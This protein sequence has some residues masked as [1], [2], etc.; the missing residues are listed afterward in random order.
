MFKYLKI[1][2]I[3]MILYILAVPLFVL[4]D[5]TIL[6][7]DTSG[8]M[9]IH[10][11]WEAQTA[12]LKTLGEIKGSVLIIG[13]D[14]NDYEI[15]RGDIS[16]ANRQAV[17]NSVR[18]RLNALIPKGPYTH[19]E[20]ALDCG[21]IF[22]MS[23]SGNGLRKLILFT[24]G[25]NRPVQDVDK[26]HRPIDLTQVAQTIIPKDFGFSVY[27]IGLT[28]DL[29]KFF[30]AKSDSTGFISDNQYPHIKG[31]PVNDYKPASVNQAFSRAVSDTLSPKQLV[32]K[33]HTMLVS[34]VGWLKNHWLLIGLIIIGIILIIT[35]ITTL[36][37]KKE[38]T[39]ITP[40]T[41]LKTKQPGDIFINDLQLLI[42][43]PG[44]PEVHYPLTEGTVYTLGIDVPIPSIDQGI[45]VIKMTSGLVTIEPLTTELIR[46][47]QEING[48]SPLSMGD[49][50]QYQDISFTLTNFLDEEMV[51][52]ISAADASENQQN[53]QALSNEDYNLL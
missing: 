47:E 45:A 22:L 53:N 23:T 30:Q 34:F 33:R 4:A 49:I 24:D 40:V 44:L 37:V 20:E 12:I 16:E 28:A 10:G 32:A 9:K 6:A 41:E 19:I 26:Y 43:C 51:S 5:V 8:S 38:S 13:F 50:I 31:I 2:V 36:K 42:Q 18:D 35:A 7:L 29:E 52:T 25:I 27:F 46:N 14:V 21:K 1:R 17:I 15:W 39:E 3:I 48:I 11:F